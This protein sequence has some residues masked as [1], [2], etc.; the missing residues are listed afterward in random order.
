MYVGGHVAC[1]GPI[2][3][4]ILSG[5]WQRQDEMEESAECVGVSPCCRSGVATRQNAPT[6]V[7][8]FC[9]S[10]KHTLQGKERR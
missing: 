2:K 7:L 4:A 8:A 3:Q 6:A 10:T 1:G 9:G 5:N